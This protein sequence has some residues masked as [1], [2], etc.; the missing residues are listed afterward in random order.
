[1]QP[2]DKCCMPEVWQEKVGRG[3]GQAWGAGDSVCMPGLPGPLDYALQTRR[4]WLSLLSLGPLCLVQ[5]WKV[6]WVQETLAECRNKPPH[7]PVLP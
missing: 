4:A 1:M 7:R 2:T 3:L 6:I 5:D